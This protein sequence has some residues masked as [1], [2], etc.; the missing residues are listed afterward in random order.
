MGER[1]KLRSELST[2]NDDLSVKAS[3]LVSLKVQN[4]ITIAEYENL[5][6][7]ARQAEDTVRCDKVIYSIHVYKYVCK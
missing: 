3:E 6:N 5:L 4:N 1:N 2:I 7:H